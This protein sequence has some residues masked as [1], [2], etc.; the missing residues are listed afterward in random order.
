MHAVSA[1][2]RQL[3]LALFLIRASV[4]LML[5]P[6]VADKFINPGH[7]LRVFEGFYGVGGMAEVM[8]HGL[9]AAQVALLLCFAIGAWRTLSYGLV[10]LMHAASTFA[11]YRQYLDPYTGANLL[12][13]AAWPTLAAMA[14]LFLLRAHDSLLSVTRRAG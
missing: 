1:T 5:A 12:F 11:S 9:G 7:A 13:F 4:V 14:T 6:W 2:P 10:T 3:P 8:V